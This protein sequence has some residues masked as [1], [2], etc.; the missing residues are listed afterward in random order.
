M[1]TASLGHPIDLLELNRASQG[2]VDYRPEV[3]RI[4]STMY[5]K[6]P[7]AVIRISSSGK[8][9][10]AQCKSE[11]EVRR[12]VRKFIRCLREWGFVVK[13]K[14]KITIRNIVC[15]VD[16]GK[17]IGC[18]IIQRVFPEA[19]R[20][21]FGGESFLIPLKDGTIRI[22]LNGKIIGLGFQNKEMAI[23][24]IERVAKELC[25][26]L[27]LYDKERAKICRIDRFDPAIVSLKECGEKLY[28]SKEILQE[29]EGLILQYCARRMRDTL[30]H[31]PKILAG[32]A[33]YLASLLIKGDE[34]RRTQ[35]DIADA[36]QI[37]EVAL[38]NGFKTI[39]KTLGFPVSAEDILAREERNTTES[40]KKPYWSAFKSRLF[41]LK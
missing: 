22:F 34:R 23:K 11:I 19:K 13:G 41:L 27:E 9:I 20:S 15:S 4:G 32:G 35:K 36:L 18:G 24:V 8:L 2:R 1:A 26:A 7:R 38:R 3:D 37:H 5:L 33:I 30:G 21:K 39:A 29:A 17:K 25:S 12:A 40:N 14:P 16:L 31:D 28:L 10:C 6:K